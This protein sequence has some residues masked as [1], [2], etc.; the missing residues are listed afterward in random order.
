MIPR[1]LTAEERKPVPA[2]R[3]EAVVKRDG[4]DVVLVV[5]DDGALPKGEIKTD[6]KADA[7]KKAPAAGGRVSVTPVTVS[8]KVG[9]LLRVDGVAP[10]TRVVLNPTDKLADGRAVAAAKK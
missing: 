8:G 9:D 4:K 7:A 6:A 5:K 3:A 10:G 1:P 2:V